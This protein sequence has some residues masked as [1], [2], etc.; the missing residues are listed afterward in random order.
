M[1]NADVRAFIAA[2]LDVQ[3]A[4]AIADADEVLRF[5]SAVIRGE[6][7]DQFGLDAALSDRLKA[8][9]ELLKRY[10]IADDR[11]RG[12]LGRLDELLRVFREAVYDDGDADQ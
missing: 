9:Q 1:A 8:A 10:A 12:T 4:Q 7:K 11:Q 6:V 5:L 2:R 3:E